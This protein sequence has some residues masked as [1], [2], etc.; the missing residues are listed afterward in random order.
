MTTCSS[1]SK[2]ILLSCFSLF[3]LCQFLGVAFLAIGLWA[4][5]EKVSGVLMCNNKL[6]D[7]FLWSFLLIGICK[8]SINPAYHCGLYSTVC[9]EWSQWLYWIRKECCAFLWDSWTMGY[10]LIW[11]ISQICSLCTESAKSRQSTEST[12]S[13][14][15]IWRSYCYL[16]LHTWLQLILFNYLLI[17]KLL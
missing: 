3:C 11:C 2:I 10:E 5:S 7:L 16:I 1:H 12:V 14:K 9:K 8:Y 6:Q 17:A 4:W 15:H 13:L